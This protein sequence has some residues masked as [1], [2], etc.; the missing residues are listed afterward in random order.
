[1]IQN[2]SVQVQ[3]GI[4]RCHHEESCREES[5][6]SESD[7]FHADTNDGLVVH[8][9][10]PPWT[11]VNGAYYDPMLCNNVWHTLC[12]KRQLL[13]QC[14][15]LVPQDKVIPHPV[16]ALLQ[17]WLGHPC[18]SSIL[19]SSCSVRFLFVAH[20]KGSPKGLHICICRHHQY[21]HFGSLTLR[22][23]MSYIYIWSTDSWCF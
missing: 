1:M 22:R 9:A 2:C 4:L 12:S 18:T 6:C 7:A 20:V 23:L 19:V 8:H 13:L 3:N 15:L 14:G 11:S 17:D 21:C 16:Q 5:R 10:V